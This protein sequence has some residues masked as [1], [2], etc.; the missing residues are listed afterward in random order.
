MW[1][2]VKLVKEY[3]GK[4]IWKDY[5]RARKDLHKQKASKQTSI[6]LKESRKCLLLSCIQIRDDAPFER[7]SESK[8]QKIKKDKSKNRKLKNSSN[9]SSTI[10]RIK[11][12]YQ[13]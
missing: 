9:N 7:K 12:T 13:N 11:N 10:I 5:G 8:K 3:P 6:Q 4:I 1:L 2:T